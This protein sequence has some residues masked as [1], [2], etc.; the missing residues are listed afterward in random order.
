[1]AAKKLTKPSGGLFGDYDQRVA[2]EE[3]ERKTSTHLPLIGDGWAR[4][5]EKA[6]P[7]ARTSDC[8]LCPFH[9]G[10]TTVCMPP[11]S[12]SPGTG[13][14]LVVQ[15]SPTRADDV[16]GEVCQTGLTAKI[17]GEVSK[18]FD[19]LVHL[20]NAI[21][22]SSAPPFEDGP[23]EACRPYVTSD[24]LD[25]KPD[26]IVVLGDVAARSVFGHKVQTMGMRRS[27]GH[28]MG[29]PV[30]VI[31]HPGV[32]VHNRIADGWFKTD[33][34]WAVT[35][36]VHPLS[37]GT[38]HV[39]KTGQEV[40]DWVKTLPIG[41]EVEVDIEYRGDYWIGD[42]ELLCLGACVDP[43][44][45]VVITGKAAHEGKAALK[46][47]LED[48]R[49]LKV[50]H[51]FKSDR[52]GIWR[53][54]DIDVRGV[55][56]DTL[57]WARMRESDSPAGLKALAWN[58]GWGGYAGDAIDEAEDQE[59]TKSGKDYGRIEPDKLHQYNARDVVVTHH[60]RKWLQ[61]QITRFSGTWE[62]LARPAQN[63]LGHVERWGALLSA[64]NVRTYDRW[65]QERLQRTDALLRAVPGV[66]EGFNPASPM[67]VS[68]HLFQTVGLMPDPSWKNTQG[69]SVGAETLTA[70]K[71]QHPLVPLL[72][73]HVNYHTQLKNYGNKMLAHIG[74]DGRVHSS[75]RIVR[76]GRLGSS[77]P[78]LQNICA[79]GVK[80]G[81][82]GYEE[83]KD[84]DEGIWA[85]GCWVASPG[86]LLVNLDYAQA[87]L[88]VA[89]MLS[90]D[91]TMAAAFEAGH[92]FH[93]MT[94]SAAF[95]VPPEEVTAEMRKV[96][97][98]I[99]F[100][101]TFGMDEFGLAATA[102]ITVAKAKELMSSLLSK[103]VKFAAWQ[104]QQIA[105]AERTGESFVRWAPEGSPL[106]WVHR[107]NIWKIGEK[108]SDKMGK[109][110][111]KHA[112]NVALNNPIQNMANCFSLAS[113]TEVVRWILDEDVPARL[114]IT[115]HDSLV[116][117]AREDVAE[118]VG[119]KVAAIMT[120]WPS[121]CVNL[122]ADL[123][124]GPDW[125]HLTK[126]GK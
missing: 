32:T 73:E 87:E 102:G 60:V 75:Y 34:K 123:E 72:I 69:Y 36:E 38:I 115:V 61:P 105:T 47:W 109:K 84:Q 107:R 58:V 8:N 5:V 101:L 66:P 42:F 122:K 59:K 55:S 93:K 110:D 77:E 95:G 94:G 76:S 25:L 118:E 33:I 2:A 96:S 79:P 14:I 50:G 57:M 97:K 11:L 113:L 62:G 10:V 116:L 80:P 120:Q 1:M 44:A 37:E 65:L 64:D 43:S 91:E 16:V 28:V 74:H 68:K 92:D 35:A 13:G 7:A 90:G 39:L 119:H 108:N 81:D 89:A 83:L 52:H 86:H 18:H 63:A 22:C 3:R 117:E 125:G 70:L 82:K 46:E 20:T 121:G 100:A 4:G 23:I 29:I 40:E 24:I 41:Q 98:G 27:W 15:S 85:R 45:P 126:V 48:S 17:V 53:A 30:F 111:R 124:I 56:V 31:M 54:L 99:N 12:L 67:Q 9:V 49:Y 26:R 103:Y 112:V 6:S 78:N 88:R 21:S 106:E 19:G 104:K 114:V 51:N 71:D